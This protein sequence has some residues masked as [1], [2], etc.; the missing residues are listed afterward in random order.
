M[1]LVE[2]LNAHPDP[3]TEAETRVEVSN[4]A[5][6]SGAT[7]LGLMRTYTRTVGV[8]QMGYAVFFGRSAA[9]SYETGSFY[10]TESHFKD[11]HIPEHLDFEW[12]NFTTAC[13]LLSFSG[14]IGGYG[15]L[16]LR[17]WVRRWEVAYLGIFSAVMATG[18]IADLPKYQL[19]PIYL[20]Y[21][22][23]G[24]MAFTL[25]YV[26]FLFGV[27]RDAAG[28]YHG[29]T[30]ITVSR[31]HA[32]ECVVRTGRRSSNLGRQPDPARQVF[33]ALVSRPHPGADVSL[34][35]RSEWEISGRPPAIQA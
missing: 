15:L 26:P 3:I 19:S 22:I 32:R 20:T 17:P 7:Q 25:P 31:D 34:T 6:Q 8:I 4:P 14:L 5:C 21:D 18:V 35:P 12:I 2:P 1:Q 33:A 13:A 27:A 29:R 28:G 24:F 30:R 16:Q 10:H 23:L 11:S 9:G